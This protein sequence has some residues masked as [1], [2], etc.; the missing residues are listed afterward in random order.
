MHYNMVKRA[1]RAY[2]EEISNRAH[3]MPE[4]YNCINALQR[5]PFRINVPVFQ[6]MKTVYKKGLPIAG[7]PSG[8]L[9][10][11]PKP[12]D[13]A[14][15]KEARR[16]YSRKASP[17]YSYN[18][19]I[20]SK[21]ILTEKIFEVADTYEQ[22]GEF[23]FPLQY[24]FRGR[25]YC[26]PEGLNYQQNDLAKGLLVFR[27]GKK[28]GTQLAVDR[29]AVHGANMYGHDKDILQNRIKWVN[30]NEKSIIQSAEDPHG[31]YEFWAEASE[32][33]QFLAFC[34]EW[35]DFVKS[36]K[37][38]DFVTNLICYS[39]CTNSGLQ[40]FSAL[41][42]DETGG[43][44]VNL[45]PSNKVQDVYGEVANATLDLLDAE[46]DS[47][48]KK[49][50]M[51]YGI[52]RK[53]TKKVTMCIV[54]GLTQFSCRKYI[55]QHLE[56]MQEDGIKDIPFSTDR[57]PIPGVPNIFKGTA[58]LSRFVWKALDDVI[59]S[60]KEAMKW[61]QDTSKLVA[62][63]GM[64]VV[65]TT[66]TGFKVQLVCPVLETKRINTYMG[67]KIY[68]PKSRKYTPDIRKTT[69]ALDPDKI[70]KRK[71][72][73]SISPCFV[74]ALDG[75][76]LQKAVCRANGYGINNFA[77]VHD[78]FGVLATDVQLMNQ[79]L[80]EAF[81]EIFDGKNLLE[82]FKEEILPQVAPEKQSKV[83]PVPAQGSLELKQVLGS[84][85]FCS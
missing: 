74:H 55:Q 19:T 11:P 45:V 58:Y 17:I 68:R 22:F 42:K 39:D 70:D 21:A 69:I 46:P 71:V 59:I 16:E 23:Y 12:F 85:Y 40:I 67:E 25:I 6:V 36:G 8:K 24:D 18:S 81:V 62:E 3:E 83:K 33:A 7:L 61:L 20:D 1:S 43:N 72:A 35:N 28:I 41:L 34:F 37:S 79:S 4:V 54:Y 73:N 76:V 26:V 65:W 66:P 13:I 57:N 48:M 27:N 80:R 52:N 9:P 10:L 50:W 64:S 31:N 78:S 56:E 53:T 32:P 75:A 15:N 82:E 14:T 63:N 51:D 60:A 49:I 77:C 44:A 30:D 29:L 47:Q 38:L 84:F 2:L 5:T